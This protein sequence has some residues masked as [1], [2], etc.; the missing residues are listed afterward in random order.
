MKKEAAARVGIC[1][2][3]PSQAVFSGSS[4]YSLRMEQLPAGAREE[5]CPVPYEQTLILL[6]GTLEYR[7]AGQSIPMPAGRLDQGELVFLAIPP[8]TQ[9][10]LHNGGGQSARCLRLSFSPAGKG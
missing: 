9:Y 7:S 8:G 6:G 3:E 4:V 1:S 5:F 2:F 10:A